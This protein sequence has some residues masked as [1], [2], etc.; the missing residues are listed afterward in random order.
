MI[1]KSTEI[2]KLI[3]TGR[4]NRGIKRQ[5]KIFRTR[6]TIEKNVQDIKSKNHFIEG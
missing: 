2:G 3:K 5:L 4:I 1:N 6:Q